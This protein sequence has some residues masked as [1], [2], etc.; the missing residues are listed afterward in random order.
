M[1]VLTLPRNSPKTP[2]TGNPR[3]EIP[4]SPFRGRGKTGGL[5]GDAESGLKKGEKAAAMP[6]SPDAAMDCQSCAE[7]LR[8]DAEHCL[9]F[10][11]FLD[12]RGRLTPRQPGD[13]CTEFTPKE[14][15][16]AEDC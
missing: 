12:R 10:V 6:P 9:R 5:S 16:H 14:P 11:V 8:P 3:P 2:E 4:L 1:A 7:L 15:T 13:C